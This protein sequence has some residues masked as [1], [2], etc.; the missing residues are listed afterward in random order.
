MILTFIPAVLTEQESQSKYAEM[1]FCSE[2]RKKIESG[3][4]RNG[5]KLESDMAFRKGLGSILDPGVLGTVS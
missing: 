2:E 4:V 3:L 5:I 1:K